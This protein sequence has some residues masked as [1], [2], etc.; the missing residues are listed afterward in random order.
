MDDKK[1]FEDLDPKAFTE[2]DWQDIFDLLERNPEK[3]LAMFRDAKVAAESEKI[4]TQFLDNAE[5]AQKIDNCMAELDEVDAP[6]SVKQFWYEM[7]RSV[8]DEES[9]KKYTP[10]AERMKD[11]DAFWNILQYVYNVETEQEDGDA[12]DPFSWQ[13]LGKPYQPPIF[14]RNR[15]Y[16][17]NHEA[18]LLSFDAESVAFDLPELQNY[19]GRWPD[20]ASISFDGR[21]NLKFQF[22]DAYTESESEQ[23]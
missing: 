18:I 10:V 7:M 12:D 1:Y 3:F 11:I 5:R 2:Q 4:L 6:E 8:D 15:E 21:M 19:D 13:Y 17:T 20:L 16:G 23:N 22:F 14:K 9:H